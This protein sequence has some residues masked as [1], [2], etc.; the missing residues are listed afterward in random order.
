MADQSNHSISGIGGDP[1]GSHPIGILA[2]NWTP[3]VDDMSIK[4][5]A[6]PIMAAQAATS[7]SSE[8]YNA[9]SEELCI[10]TIPAGTMFEIGD[11]GNTQLKACWQYYKQSNNNNFNSGNE[12]VPGTAASQDAGTWTDIGSAAKDYSTDTMIP[13]DHADE[14]LMLE[15]VVRLRVKLVVEDGA[16]DG[17]AQGLVDAGVAAVNAAHVVLPI[18]K[19]AKKN[20]TI[21]NPITFGGIG[22][23][24]S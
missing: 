24:P 14:D 7:D 8:D 5:T 23:D 9:Y 1:S 19:Q 12:V 17:V 11:T 2:S 22:A 4:Y 21:N 20:D 15:G 18:D 6:N 13:A 3:A 16:D 10:G